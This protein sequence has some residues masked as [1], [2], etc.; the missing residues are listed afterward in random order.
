MAMPVL[1]MRNVLL[2]LSSRKAHACMIKDRV[3]TYK[4]AVAWSQRV[5]VTATSKVI[6]GRN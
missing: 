1:L 3:K 2:N 5:N 4:T 6:Q